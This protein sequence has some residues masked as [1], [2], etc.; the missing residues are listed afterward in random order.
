VTAF[1][2]SRV[3][4]AA[5]V[6][7]LGA[8][9]AFAQSDYGRAE[10]SASSAARE[11]AAQESVFDR[12][13]GAV[14]RLRTSPTSKAQQAA[15][16]A[17]PFG[18]AL[19]GATPGWSADEAGT[20]PRLSFQDPAERAPGDAKLEGDLPLIEPQPDPSPVD[21]KYSGPEKKITEILPYVDYEP[22]S[23]IRR[24]DPLRNQCPHP[25]NLCPP[26]LRLSD[27]LWAPRE[28]TPSIFTWEASNLYHYPLYF[29][30]PDL[31]R[32]GHT[33]GCVVQPLDS[34]GKFSLQLVGL[35]YQMTI[36][37]AWRKIYTLGWYRPGECA[38]KLHYQIP[39]HHQA[40][41][42]Q[43]LVTTGLFYLI[44]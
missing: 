30:D 22:D 14:R 35:P 17:D 7:F 24:T 4:A 16:S 10:L 41:I 43:A 40:A 25:D 20:A 38:P 26:E 29:E 34:I 3:A 27:S 32:Y 19:S 11:P 36:D 1:R 13:K 28:I 9:A 23:E 21:R 39:W 15:P 2:R 33:Y 37:P 12:L 31:E 42:N 18:P 6:V 5:L 8:S 44:P